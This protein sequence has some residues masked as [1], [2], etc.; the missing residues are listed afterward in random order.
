[1]KISAKAEYACLTVIPLAT[2]EEQARPV[3]IREIAD[4]QGIPETFLTQ[5]LLKLKAAGFVQSTRGA[6]GV[7]RLDRPA[8]RISL[9]DRAHH[10]RS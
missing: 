6:S 5:I 9:G 7:Y 2:F 4:V 3:R 1:V 10:R 8:D